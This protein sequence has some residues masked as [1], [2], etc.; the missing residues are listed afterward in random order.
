MA[1]AKSIKSGQ[2]TDELYSSNW[3]H[4]DKLT[5]LVPV[6]GASKRRSI[7]KRINLQEHE[8]KKE[9][10]GKPVAKRK[11]LAE[12]RLDLLSICTEAITTNA[13]WIHYDKLT[14]LVPVTGASKRRSILKR[15]NLQEHENKK[16]VG[17]KPVAKRKTLAEKRLDLLSIC[18]E[19]ITTNANTKAPTK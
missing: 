17:G 18:T 11:T 12:K 14:F 9:V 8:N 7:L 5:F 10:G 1:K 6:T 4:Y 19:A 2:S 3:I 16:E 13:N 15:I